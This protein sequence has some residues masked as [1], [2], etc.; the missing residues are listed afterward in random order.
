MIGWSIECLVDSFVFQSID[1][2]SKTSDF[3]LMNKS[4]SIAGSISQIRV[5][6]SLY[7][8]TVNIGRRSCAGGIGSSRQHVSSRI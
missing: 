1:R 6:E 5:D 7:R 3:H 8:E 4:R 2:F